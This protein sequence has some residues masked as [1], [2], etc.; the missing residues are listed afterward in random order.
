M[1]RSS[2]KGASACLDFDGAASAVVIPHNAN[3]LLTG[4]FTFLAR[5]R[6]RSFGETAGVVLDKST[7]TSGNDGW[8]WC[9][10]PGASRMMLGVNSGTNIFASS[11]KLKYNGNW[12][13][14]AV[15]VDAAALVT[16][17]LR[18]LVSGTPGTTGALS[19]IT[20]TNAM[21][22]GNRSTATD[23]TFDGPI[24]DVRIFNRVLSA[25]EIM[26]ITTGK[27]FDRT[28]LIGEYFLTNKQ[29]STASVAADT[30]PSANHGAISSATYSASTPFVNRKRNLKFTTAARLNGSSS[31]FIK[32]TPTGIN[33]GTDSRS[34]LGRIFLTGAT[35]N[36]LG[37]FAQFK[38]S[39]INQ[40]PGFLI[41]VLGGIY[42][43]AFDTLNGTNNLTITEAEFKRHFKM[44][45]WLDVA[46][47][48]T[49]TTVSLYVNRV[50]V[51]TK[52]WGVPINTGA[53]TSLTFGKGTTAAD[54]D[55][56]FGAW[57]MKDFLIVNG[58]PTVEEISDWSLKGIRPAGTVDG[59]QIEEGTGQD[60]AD[61]VGSN[62]LTGSNI[63]WDSNVPT[64]ARS[65]AAGRQKANTEASVLASATGWVS[66]NDNDLLAGRNSTGVFTVTDWTQM[67]GGNFDLLGMVTLTEGV[68]FTAETSNEVTAS[69][70]ADALDIV[71]G[72]DIANAVGAVVTVVVGGED[73]GGEI[74][75]SG[76]GVSPTT[77]VC[78]GGLDKIKI[79]LNGA[80]FTFP[81]DVAIGVDA[82]ASASNL[83]T[84]LNGF[85]GLGAT[86]LAVGN[87]VTLTAPAGAA[88][89]AVTLAVEGSGGGPI[90][91]DVTI[92]GATLTGGADA[93]TAQS[94]SLA[95]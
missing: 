70:I 7:G 83:A 80:G 79:S 35:D 81:D 39:L 30:S 14:V 47:C 26:A 73:E 54:G 12:E 20:T 92:S 65:T 45:R 11:Q 10:D 56:Y 87:V 46:F 90:E 19:G 93:A 66:I 91:D 60:T 52:T 41:G 23:R 18:G 69:N 85:G 29:G 51:T 34:V 62:N 89:N 36:A 67:S 58:I 55:V 38:R 32:T 76:T 57:L 6:P 59:Y 82:D 15:T 40:S 3:Q 9:I 72:E 44:L 17:Y 8:R 28:G 78:S 5:I 53:L 24:C 68:D 61:D 71:A 88:G 86:A 49:T 64:K 48:M 16:H 42:Y 37:C 2:A 77:A 33:T 84:A 50:L 74:V 95:S 43:I 63:T 22:I 31:F 4:G 25:E 94:R 75:W 21:T 1:P 13:D 27:D